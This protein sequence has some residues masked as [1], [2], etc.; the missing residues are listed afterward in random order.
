MFATSQQ[1]FVICIPCSRFL[2]HYSDLDCIIFTTEWFWFHPESSLRLCGLVVSYW[3]DF[4]KT[5]IM[6]G[7]YSTFLGRKWC[8]LDWKSH[9]IVPISSL[10]WR[11][12]LRRLGLLGYNEASILLAF[13]FLTEN[14]SDQKHCG[15]ELITCFFFFSLLMRR[16][17]S[18][19]RIFVFDVKTNL[20]HEI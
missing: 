13:F 12:V 9:K 3:A 20:H 14:K 4:K 10:I 19:S 5:W 15:H 1:C 7:C 17:A 2:H 8:F 11:K 6:F 18:Y 16:V